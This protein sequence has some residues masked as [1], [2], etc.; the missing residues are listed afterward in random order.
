MAN[1][2]TLESITLDETNQM[3]FKLVILTKKKRR[4][5]SWLILSA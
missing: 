4:I 2:S 5:W 1:L 3:R